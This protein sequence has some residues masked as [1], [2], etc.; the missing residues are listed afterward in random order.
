MRHLP[1]AITLLRL[2]LVPVIGALLHAGQHGVAFGLFVVS[3][4]SDA[5]DGQLARR[6]QVQSR[7][8]AIADPIA[9][10]L[11]MVVVAVLLAAQ[12]A[13]P[14]WFVALLVARDVVIVG[15]ALA[16]CWR[17]GQ[18]EMAPTPLSKLNTVLQFVL[19]LAVLAVLA[20]LLPDGAWIDLLMWAT[21]AT[22]AVS[23]AH[24]V[25]AWGRRAVRIGR[26]AA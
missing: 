9:D 12:Q 2:A 18:L 6:W 5:L 14:W 26:R 11:T 23:G 16:F 25:L 15:G 19:L 22:I 10:K 13:L 24:Y 7:F 1:N 8:G 4:V 17:V 3:A 21:L 20:G